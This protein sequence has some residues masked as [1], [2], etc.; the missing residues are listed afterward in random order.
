[1]FRIEHNRCQI[2]FSMVLKEQYNATLGLTF[3]AKAPI[4]I[5]LN[6]YN[7]SPSPCEN[8]YGNVCLE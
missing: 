1:M 7:N 6:K 2:F 8:M 3:T 4:T 5:K